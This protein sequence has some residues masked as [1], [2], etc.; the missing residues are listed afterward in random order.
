MKSV[1]QHN[2]KNNF[3]YDCNQNYLPFSVS[4]T[5][6]SSGVP[7]SVQKQ[8]NNKQTQIQN[9]SMLE[10]QVYINNLH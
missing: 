6:I 10:T 4:L 1:R 3:T 2:S 8:C 9:S 7:P 5:P